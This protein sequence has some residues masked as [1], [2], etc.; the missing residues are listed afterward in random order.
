M[1]VQ[2]KI[3]SRIQRMKRGVPFSIAVFYELGS[4]TSVQKAFSRLSKEGVI[5]RASKGFYVRPKPLANIP[6]VKVT[7]SAEQVARAWARKNNHKLV[8]QGL[9]AAYRIGFQTQAPMKK[10]F[11]TSGPTRKFK[12]GNEVVEARHITPSK[13]NWGEKPEGLLLRSMNVTSPESVGV[14]GLK[15]A[16]SRLSLSPI[17][18][19]VVVNKLRNSKL[20][21]EWEHTLTHYEEAM[22]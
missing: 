8:S 20:P 4:V 22:A 13:L 3:T 5:E 6:S 17:E 18:V 2:A 9:E 12:M 15:T 16:F 10:I 14:S 19:R 21:S 11:W 1:S 7:T